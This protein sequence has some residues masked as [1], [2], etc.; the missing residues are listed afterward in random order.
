MTNSDHDEASE[1]SEASEAASSPDFATASPP[2]QRRI[3]VACSGGLLV[4]GDRVQN[5]SESRTEPERSAAPRPPSTGW[6]AS[7]PG[8][9]DLLVALAYALPAFAVV[10]AVAFGDHD[11]IQFAITS[12]AVA[13][14]GLALLF[15]RRAP[16]LV[17]VLTT[18]VMLATFWTPGSI[19]VIAVGCALYAVTVYRSVRG[20]VIGWGVV[21]VLLVVEGA[22]LPQS[23][24]SVGESVQAIVVLVVA[25]LV[26]LSVRSSRHFAAVQLAQLAREREQDVAA[27]AAA[28]RTSIAREMHDIVSHS[29]SVMI[30]LAHGSAEIATKEPDR[31]VEGMR[32][33]ARTGRGALGDMRRMLGVLRDAPDG[34]PADG[35]T[36][37]PGIEDLPALLERF[38]ATGL[39]VNMRSTGDAPPDAVMQ[40][41]VYRIVQ[42]SLTNALK[43]ARGATR[44]AVTITFAPDLVT[45]IVDDDGTA[46]ETAGDD[47]GRGLVGIGERVALYSGRVTTG[48]RDGGGWAMHAQL[49]PQVAA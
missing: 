32:E 34:R 22:L 45:V 16:V 43:Y 15:R 46:D 14:S 12:C 24:A 28:E 8:V 42:E 39:P 38:R 10:L 41:T 2:E 19:A 20:A 17:F 18:A 11:A 44:V 4:S 33:V 30:S 6:L 9:T 13:A 40:L 36:S 21:G 37:T 26:G 48:P 47:L 49:I 5:M 35:A 29:L 25:V 31:A 1:A 27:A 3:A 23:V 7:R